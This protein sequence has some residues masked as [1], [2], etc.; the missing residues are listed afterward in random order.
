MCKWPS[1]VAVRQKS[2]EPEQ[3]NQI[4]QSGQSEVRPGRDVR[5]APATGSVRQAKGPDCEPLQGIIQTRVFAAMRTT[6]FVLVALLVAVFVPRASAAP[7][8]ETF[9]CT[10]VMGV[11][12]TG[13]WY[14]A[15]F[16]S[17]ND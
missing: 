4:R 15:G 16:E 2:E 13:D 8:R 7:K 17:G 1:A 3:S 9:V 12:V 5:E 6:V 14:N 10:Q 11:S